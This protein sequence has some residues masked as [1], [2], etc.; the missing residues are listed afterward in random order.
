MSQNILI[1][2]AVALGPNAACRVKRLDP[3]ARV[4]MVDQSD[5]ISYGGCGIPYFVSGDVSEATQLQETSFHMLR[6]KTFFS[7]AKDV[8][9]MI[10]TRA[11]SIDRD[12]KTVR[13]KNVLSGQEQELAYDKLVLATGSRPR[14]LSVPGAHLEGVYTVSDLNNAIA[15]KQE[16]SAGKVGQAVIIGGGFIGLE[17]AEALTDLWGI[18]TTVIEITDQ[19][20][21]GIISPNLS[22]MVQ[23]HLEEHE[24]AIYL[25]EEVVR[26]EGDRRVAK[27]VTARRVLDAD[28]VIVA[29]GNLPNSELAKDAGL[30]VSDRGGIVVNKTRLLPLGF[31]G[32]PT[33]ACDRYQSGR[34]P[35]RV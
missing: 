22:Q 16:I 20:L 8:D 21:P 19:L 29:A 4:I 25:E 28:L 11:L 3:D 34:R 33:G 24:V 1:I 2:G 17:M 7:Q 27:V 18:E 15:V 14:E 30:E 9:V 12:H 5:L 13:V 10:H 32:Q 26:F 23:H 31:F 35:S 6:D